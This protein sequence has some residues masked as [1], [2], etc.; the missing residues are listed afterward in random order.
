M[1]ILVD[2]WSIEKV[3]VYILL[4]IVTFFLVQGHH[5]LAHWGYKFS[6]NRRN[7]SYRCPEATENIFSTSSLSCFTSSFFCPPVNPLKWK[8]WFCEGQARKGQLYRKG[9]KYR[10]WLHFWFIQLVCGLWV[11]FPAAQ[12]IFPRQ[13]AVHKDREGPGAQTWT[14]LIEK[15]L[16][17]VQLLGRSNVFRIPS[18]RGVREGKS[19]CKAGAQSSRNRNPMNDSPEFK[20]T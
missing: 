1:Q 7:L 3:G 2:F 11:S 9:C 12:G 4:Q 10:K 8:T 16:A 15:A 18:S 14:P 5:P 20:Q 19:R 6:T 17:E 13:S